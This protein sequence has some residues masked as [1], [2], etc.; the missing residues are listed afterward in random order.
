MNRECVRGLWAGQLQEL[1]FLRNRNPERGSIQ[2][3]KQALRNM[4]NSSCDQP[5]GY[6]IYVS[7][8]TT[9]YSGTND[10]YTSIIGRESSYNAFFDMF[11]RLWHRQVIKI[12]EMHSV[13]QGICPIGVAFTALW[14]TF[15]QLFDASELNL[16]FGVPN[17]GAKFH[18]N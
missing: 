16:T 13:K 12:L 2:N 10:Q 11:R 6:P 8:L 9:S 7:P 5:I 14:L 3:A 1:I 18:Q 15:L 4:I 17:Y